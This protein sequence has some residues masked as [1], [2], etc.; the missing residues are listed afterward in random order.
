MSCHDVITCHDLKIGPNNNQAV[1][2]PAMQTSTRKGQTQ[3]CTCASVATMSSNGSRFGPANSKP[4]YLHKLM[5]KLNNVAQ[6]LNSR[7]AD[8]GHTEDECVRVCVCALMSAW[9]NNN[10]ETMMPPMTPTTT[11]PPPLPPHIPNDRN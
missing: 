2:P 1:L 6:H 8:D 11:A 9:K 7:P 3:H 10:D 5:T 4:H